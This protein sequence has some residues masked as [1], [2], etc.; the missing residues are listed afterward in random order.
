MAVHK[1][2]QDVEAEDK[3]LGP[4]SFK[5]FLFF[6]GALITGF[7]MF[8]IVTSG[9]GFLAIL[10][11]PIFAV[12]V[13][14]AFPWTK[15]QPTE[16]WLASRI[17]F[18][19]VPRKRIWD[20]DDVKDLVT[21]TVPKREVHIYSDGLSQTQVKSR[22]NA[23]ANVI[24]SKGWAVKNPVV[25]SQTQT[26]RLAHGTMATT[27]PTAQLDEPDPYD[28]HS[29]AI[30]QHFESMIQESQE[31]HRDATR[32][33]MNQALHGGG[34]VIEPGTASTNA[35]SPWFLQQGHINDAG[36]SKFNTT[37]EE[38]LEIGRAHV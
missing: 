9:V 12:C 35:S 37:F 19:L 26:D 23:L 27:N 31:K 3:F 28:D 15:D 6:G 18:L 22:L 16:L 34:Q 11:L 30:A 7:L 20:Q 14:M 1:V 38:S 32:E 5:Q 24:D 2:P 8:Q 13:I 25:P 17:R 21:I 29:S 36:M 33:K 4:L 10:I